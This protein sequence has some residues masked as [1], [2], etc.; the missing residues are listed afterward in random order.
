M[1]VK[2]VPHANSNLVPRVFVWIREAKDHG[3]NAAQIAVN[4]QFS[5]SN[6]SIR[7]EVITLPTFR[8]GYR[9]VRANRTNVRNVNFLI[10]LRWIYPYQPDSY[11]HR[12]G[13]TFPK[14]LEAVSYNSQVPD[15]NDPFT[16]WQHK[17]L[18]H[19]VSAQV[20][21]FLNKKKNTACCWN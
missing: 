16:S 4:T 7:V 10:L 6:P 9:F 11:P 8:D 20:T 13:T 15:W 17:L 12:H 21:H 2:P 19:K 3:D 5:Y 1:N 18:R 14:E